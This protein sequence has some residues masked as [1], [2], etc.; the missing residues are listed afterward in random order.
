MT[1]G[2]EGDVVDLGSVRRGENSCDGVIGGCVQPM[3]IVEEEDDDDDDEADEKDKEE[4]D[5]E[6]EDDER[7]LFAGSITT[8]GS[9][10]LNVTTFVGD[11]VQCRM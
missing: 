7:A 11:T 8:G 2:E 10:A 9:S 4:D 3:S 1:T 5:D 6:T